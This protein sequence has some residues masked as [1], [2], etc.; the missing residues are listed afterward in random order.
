MMGIQHDYNVSVLSRIQFLKT[1]T[2]H[3][4][5]NNL[6]QTRIFKGLFVWGFPRLPGFPLGFLCIII[7]QFQ[8]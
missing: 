3:S 2:I 4:G 8:K 5:H 6:V 1:H 7:I